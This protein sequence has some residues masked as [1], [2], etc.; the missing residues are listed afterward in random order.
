MISCL[1]DI[2]NENVFVIATT[3]HPESLDICLRRTG[4]FDRE[5]NLGVPDR[6][7]RLKIIQKMSKKLNISYD[8]SFKEIARLTPGYVGADLEALMKESGMNAI[9]RIINILEQE[10][11]DSQIE[12]EKEEENAS[13]DYSIV[14]EDIQLAL[15][16]I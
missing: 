7:A 11:Q 15:A 5:I 3:S 10:K 4:R 14:F 16:K 12:I 6:N 2:K 1:D 13:T 8:V 9:R